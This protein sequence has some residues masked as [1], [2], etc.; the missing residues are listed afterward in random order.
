MTRA[1]L[2]WPSMA[3]RAAPVGGNFETTA[4]TTAA[5]TSRADA[6]VECLRNDTREGLRR[7]GRGRRRGPN[8]T[9]LLLEAL[10]GRRQ[11]LIHSLSCLLPLLPVYSMHAFDW[12]KATGTHLGTKD[13]PRRLP[14]AW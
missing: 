13:H 2:V 7:E 9:C 12:R 8:L 3:Q 4:T 6:H 5:G 1:C 14:P 10:S 11:D